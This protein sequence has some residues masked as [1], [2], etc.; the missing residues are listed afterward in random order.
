MKTFYLIISG[1]LLSISSFSQFTLKKIIVIFLTMLF[2]FSANSQAINEDNAKLISQNWANKHNLDSEITNVIRK[3]IENEVLLYIVSFKKGW[4]MVAADESLKPILGF[5]FDTFYNLDNEPETLESLFQ[6]Y[7]Q[8]KK[9]DEMD[10]NIFTYEWEAIKSTTYKSGTISE[11]IEPLIPVNWAQGWPYNAYCPLDDDPDLPASFNGHHNTSCGPTAF[12]QILKYWEYPEHGRGYNSYTYNYSGFAQLG[13]VEANFESTYYNWDNMPVTLNFDDPESTY[14]DIATLMFHAAVSVDGA[15]GGGSGLYK[16]ATAAIE[17]FNFSPTCKVYFR[18]DFSSNE[19]HTIF[20]NELNNN[21]PIMISGVSENGGGHYFVCDGYYGDDFYHINWGW[22]GSANGYFPLYELGNYTVRNYAIIGLEPNYEDKELTMKDPYTTDN[23]TIVLLHFNG[24][25]DN[26]SSL[27]ANPVPHG[28]Y[29]FEDNSQLDLGQ[30][31][32]LDNDNQNN[33]SFLDIIDNDNLDLSGNW[34]IEMW[35]KLNSIGGKYT[36][37]NKTGDNDNFNSNYSIYMLPHWDYYFPNGLYCSFHPTGEPEYYRSWINTDRDFIEQGKWYHISYIRDT[38]DYTHTMIIHNADRELIHKSSRPYI[39]QSA[40]EPLL[41]SNPLFIGTSN[42]PNTYFNGYIDEL[43]IS[44]VV[45]E[46]SVTSN[47]LPALDNEMINNKIKALNLHRMKH[48]QSPFNPVIEVISKEDFQAQ[49]PGN[50]FVFDA[51]YVDTDGKVYISEPESTEQLETFDNINQAA[52][53]YVCQSFLQYYYQSTEMPIWFKTGF[54]SYESDIRIDDALIK[55]AYENYNNTLTSFAVLNDPATFTAN[56]GFAVSYMF[57]E[58]MGVYKIWEY[59]LIQEVNAST[60]VPASWWWNIESLDRLFEIWMRYF[61]AR[62]LEENEES[63][64]KLNLES[65]NF[66]FYYRDADAYCFPHFSEVLENALTEYMNLLDFNTYEKLSYITMPECDFAQIDG[67]ECLNRYTGGTAWSSGLSST[68][69]NNENDFYRFDKLIRHELGHLAGMQL[70]NGQLTAWLNEGLACFMEA[71]PHNQERKDELQ[72]ATEEALNEATNYFEHQ[73]TFEDTKVYPNPYFNYYL[74]GEI[75]LN[76]IYEEGGYPAIRKIMLDYESGIE[77]LGYSS[78]QIFMTDY[79][80]YLNTNYLKINNTKT[81]LNPYTADENTIL[82]MHFDDNLTNSSTQSSNGNQ[83]GTGLS[84]SSTTPFTQGKSLQLNGNS[85]FTVPHTESLNLNGDWTIEM[86]F[87]ITSLNAGLINKPASNGAANYNIHIEAPDGHME[88]RFYDTDGNRY[89]INTP[90]QTIETNKWYHVAFINNS[91]NNSIQLLLKNEAYESIFDQ[92]LSYPAET[93]PINSTYN[94]SIGESVIGM[95]D[96][97]RISNVVRDFSITHEYDWQTTSSD[98]FDYYY[99]NSSLYSDNLNNKLQSKFDNLD[100]TILETWDGIN[101]LDR[102]NKLKIYL[103]EAD[104]AF[105]SAPSNLPDWDIGYYKHIENELHI[106]VPSSTRQLKYFPDLNRAA[107]SVL[108]RY[109]MGKKYASVHNGQEPMDGISFGFGLFESGY[110]PDLTLLQNYL[111]ANNNTM[112][113]KSTISTWDQLEDET[114]TELAYTF[115]FASIFRYGYLSPTIQSGLYNSQKDI[116]Y[117]IFRLFFIT[118]I[119]N[120]GMQKFYDGD[121]FIVYANDEEVCN[122]TVE[123]LKW[124]ADQYENSFEARINH[125]L[126]VTIYGSAETY[127]YTRRGNINNI[128]NGGEALSHSLLRAGPA[129]EN[130]NSE[131]NRI[132]TKYSQGHEFM[133]NTFASLAITSP[134]IWLNEGSAMYAGVDNLQGYNGITVNNLSNWHEF[135]WTDRDMYFPDLSHVF[136]LDASFG[137]GMAFSSF[138]FIKDRFSSETLLQFMKRADDFSILG[139]ENIDHFQRHLYEF[140]YRE[141]MPDFLFKPLW[142]TET[143]YNPESSFTFNWEGHYIQDL[144]FAYSIDSMKS[145]IEIGDVSMSSGAYSWSIPNSSN[146]I[147]RISDKDFNDIF[148]TYQILG[149]KPKFDKVLQMNF[150]NG[151]NNLREPKMNGRLKGEVNFKQ[152]EGSNGKYAEFDGVWDVIS[153]QNY[154]KISLKNNWTIQGDFMIENISGVMNHKPVLLEKISTIYNKKNYSITFN[155]YGNENL[156]FEYR[157]ENNSKIRLTID[158]AGISLGNWYKFYFARS[159]ENNIVEARVYD[160]FGNMLDNEIKSING[161]GDVQTGNGDLY[162]GSG[163]FYENEKCLQGG[164]DAIIIS[165]TYHSELMTNNENSSPLVSGIANQTIDINE[166]FTP[167]NLDDFVTDPDHADSEMTWSFS[168]ND[169]LSIN[170]DGNRIATITDTNDEWTGSE[171]IIFTATDPDGASDSDTAI[172]T[173]LPLGPEADFASNLTIGT[174]PLTVEFTD[175]STQGTS[176]I[177]EWYWDFGDGESSSQQSP[178]HTYNE[179]GVYD[180]SLTITDENALTDTETKNDYIT[181]YILPQQAS[182]PQPADLS[183]SIEIEPTLN[184]T[185]CENTED[186]DLYFGTENPPSTKVLNNVSAATTFNPSAL[187]YQTDYFWKVVCRNLNGETEG[188]IWKF[189]TAIGTGLGD[190]LENHKQ[191]SIYPNPARGQVYVSTPKVVDLS[192]TT[193]SGMSVLVKKGFQGGIID[194][195]ALDKGV[196][197][198][199]LRTEKGMISRKLIIK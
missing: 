127:T 154:P 77:D 166:D 10:K 20:R 73:P 64:V 136:E 100:N 75:M 12:A 139:Y 110:S 85:Y 183:T 45:R 116:W 159:E 191:I 122:L 177:T 51:G 143:V 63:R 2:C 181:V 47:G 80:S 165:D 138:A 187:S 23:N 15:W 150:E 180:V 3:K 69:P 188:P 169:K 62:I 189:T 186:V 135:F 29:S 132:L 141:Y 37:L 164:L 57:G 128:E 140:L 42:Q 153:V 134:P 197:M 79:Y 76:F 167:I 19:W 26:Q 163:S 59:Y 162:L 1:L 137:Y 161:E 83:V 61:D 86:W 106:R 121:D 68:R 148:Y 103:Y 49:K 124:Y 114:N 72:S 11:S 126:L 107:L 7:H 25:F 78:L 175:Q 151:A 115:V 184:W 178:S 17:H 56:N 120:G 130:I 43:R 87:K 174:K 98:Y 173:I 149:N 30:C 155:K 123:G 60:I 129:T 131:L 104:Q 101:L 119:E 196:Y 4:V 32:Y 168:G 13:F 55:T 81:D 158:N 171:T 170:I 93:T 157:L 190:N 125:P 113:D 117:Q 172:F 176:T 146:C 82:L 41:N 142:N 71:G 185:I 35:F 97:L 6:F 95:I 52:L 133:H 144:T 90:A 27:S 50:A 8:I 179:V 18:D 65:E 111:D 34:T 109:V 53:Y 152:G 102:T 192:I 194:I 21:R 48:T 39:S 84:Y 24:N 44:N 88:A 9:D 112:P 70:P 38:S 28:T 58:F 14:K 31:L 67:I 89:Q 33:N 118:S 156:H 40:S 193:L 22:G 46:F 199:I 195:S 96:E 36:L 105:A 182:N 94:V 5:S 99:T 160:Q 91:E 74:L 198:I 147:L 92:N 145:W 16:Y 108:A 54:A 66:K